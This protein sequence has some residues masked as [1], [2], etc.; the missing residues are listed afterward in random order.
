MSETKY[1]RFKRLVSSR[2]QRLLR[3]IRLIGNLSNTK[4]YSYT[5][6][7]VDDLFERIDIELKETKS[8]FEQNLET[9]GDENERS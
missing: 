5:Q 7:D 2:Q 4:N 9:N 8:L 6:S 1:D 3:E